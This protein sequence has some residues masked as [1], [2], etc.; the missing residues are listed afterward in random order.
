MT[1]MKTIAAM[2]EKD[3]MAFVTEKRALIQKSRFNKT[4][5]DTSLIGKAKRDIARALTQLNKKDV[6]ASA[7]K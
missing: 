2:S 3:L 1:D 4:E 5:R 7:T 6:S